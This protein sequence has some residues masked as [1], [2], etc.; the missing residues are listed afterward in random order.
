[1][2]TPAITSTENHVPVSISFLAI[3]SMIPLSMVT[4]MKV[5]TILAK[6]AVIAISLVVIPMLIA[7]CFFVWIGLSRFVPLYRS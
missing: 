4:S 5:T 1:M 2:R 3:L 7:S 6:T